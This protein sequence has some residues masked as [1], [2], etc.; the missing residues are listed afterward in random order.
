MWRDIFLM[1]RAPL[2][3]V[4]AGYQAALERL[5]HAI[6]DN[7]GAALEAQLRRARAAREEL[8]HRS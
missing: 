7:D 8:F 3:E 2:L 1:N 5:A 6:R 4:L